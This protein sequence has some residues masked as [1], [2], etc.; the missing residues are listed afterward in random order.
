MIDLSHPI[1]SRLNPDPILNQNNFKIGDL[2]SIKAVLISFR[3]YNYI[4][5][6]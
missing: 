5:I 1:Q 3:P 4:P 2:G 6:K